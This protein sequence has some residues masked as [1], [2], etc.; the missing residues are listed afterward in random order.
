MH[1]GQVLL[2][3]H[4][5]RCLV[6]GRLK[7]AGGR[8]QTPI[9]VLY[10][11][12]QLTEDNNADGRPSDMILLL[13]GSQAGGGSKRKNYLGSGTFIC[14]STTHHH[15]TIQLLRIIINNNNHTHARTS[16]HPPTRSLPV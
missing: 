16:T 3:G 6:N 2:R 4:I 8:K 15:H 12:I 13:K 10:P 1:F 14:H 5:H 7:L 11:G 9:A